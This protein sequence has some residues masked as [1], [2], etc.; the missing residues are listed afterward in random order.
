MAGFGDPHMSTVDAAGLR[1]GIVGSR[2]HHDLVDH[3]VERAVQAAK[4]CAVTDVVVERV[5]G[6]MELPV[7]AQALAG[8]CDAVVALA[9]VIRG[10]TPHFDYVCESVTI[11]LTR[12]SLDASTP[13]GNGVLTVE[14]LGQARDRAGLP[15]SVEDKGWAS[16][17]AALDAALVLRRLTS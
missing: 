3:M 17:V 12:V 8:R 6:A 1:L 14:S 5:T 15:D 2:W 13:V 4:D 11:G 9:V 7:V 16:T 10:E